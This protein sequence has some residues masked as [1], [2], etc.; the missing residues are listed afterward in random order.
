MIFHVVCQNQL[1]GK[2]LSSD[3]IP[4]YNFHSPAS[5]RSLHCGTPA[6]ASSGCTGKQVLK[7]SLPP[8]PRHHV[9]FLPIP[10]AFCH[11]FP[12]GES[13]LPST[14]RRLKFCLTA[15]GSW[16]KRQGNLL[17]CARVVPL[18][19]LVLLAVWRQ[20]GCRDPRGSEGLEPGSP[21]WAH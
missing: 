12:A 6:K 16:R 8:N 3:L 17:F 15:S 10:A 18:W 20:W 14:R 4:A 1:L 11:A 7:T 5:A 13:F 19:L 2:H 21:C 9:A